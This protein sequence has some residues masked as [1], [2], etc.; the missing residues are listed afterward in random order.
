M[1]KCDLLPVQEYRESWMSGVAFGIVVSYFG[2]KI[3]VSFL[4]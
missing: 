2:L 3:T 4:E 1:S